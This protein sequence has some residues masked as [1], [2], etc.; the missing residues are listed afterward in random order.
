MMAL[1]LLVVLVATPGS[2]IGL[3]HSGDHASLHR[4]TNC[5][6]ALRAA[7]PPVPLAALEAALLLR[8]SAVCVVLLV[9]L[10]MFAAANAVHLYNQLAVVPTCHAGHAGT[11]RAIPHHTHCTHS[12]LN[13]Q[14]LVRTQWSVH[15]VP[16]TAAPALSAKC[17]RVRTDGLVA[18]SAECF[19]WSV[20]QA[21]CTVHE[22]RPAVRTSKTSFNLENI[23]YMYM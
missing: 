16:S 20:Y 6:G 15:R 23:G 14:S 4:R 13:A 10:M 21:K 18:L 11:T 2:I 9:L 17:T 5:G 1:C 19:R 8:C 22:S 12:A 7:V 3:A